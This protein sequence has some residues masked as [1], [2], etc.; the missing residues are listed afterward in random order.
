MFEN[1]PRPVLLAGGALAL[2]F[3]FLMFR[4]GGGQESSGVSPLGLTFASMQ[5]AAASN[6]DALAITAPRDV[7]LAGEATKRF[8]VARQF[9]AEQLN[10]NLAY[11][12]SRNQN[13]TTISLADMAHRENLEVIKSDFRL[14]RRALLNERAQQDQLF[15]LASQQVG[16]ERF[17]IKSDAELQKFA[18]QTD[19]QFLPQSFTLALRELARQE[20][21]DTQQFQLSNRRLDIA[22]T[23]ALLGGGGI[24]GAIGQA[25]TAVFG[26]NE[27]GIVGGI[28]DAIP[29]VGGIAGLFGF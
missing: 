1:I 25:G 11:F 18:L 23:Q 16:L 8:Q 24:P 2:V 21:F 28:L 5:L 19:R 3:F 4:R 12:A 20:R 27:G 29:V 6:I 26:E 22:E 17:A 7:A 14:N 9:D 13:K 10:S 15:N